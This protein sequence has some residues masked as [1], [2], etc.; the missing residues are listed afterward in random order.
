[1]IEW[2]KPILGVQGR[3]EMGAPLVTGEGEEDMVMVVGRESS[4]CFKYIAREISHEGMG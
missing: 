1:M 2:L 4:R 3:L